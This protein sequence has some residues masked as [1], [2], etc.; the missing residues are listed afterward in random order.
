MK[1]KLNYNLETASD[2]RARPL[3]KLHEGQMGCHVR[4]FSGSKN[5]RDSLQ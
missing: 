5:E 4:G 1:H 2:G 3:A